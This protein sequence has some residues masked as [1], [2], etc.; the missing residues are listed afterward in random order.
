MLLSPLNALALLAA[1]LP[2]I[3][4]D[5]APIKIDKNRTAIDIPP[6]GLGLWNSK[7]ENV[8]ARRCLRTIY[9]HV[10]DECEEKG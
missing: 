8:T 5:Q 4:A 3:R 9:L 6:I 7:D 2:Q 1:L 10:R